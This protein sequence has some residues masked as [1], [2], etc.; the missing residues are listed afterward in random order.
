MSS[1]Q[2][3]VVLPEVLATS[4]PSTVDPLSVLIDGLEGV[5]EVVF[6]DLAAKNDAGD[7]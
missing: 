7:V 4:L 6:R 3:E 2:L 1:N 5:S